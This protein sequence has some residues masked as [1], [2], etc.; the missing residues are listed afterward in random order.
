[1][2]WWPT[3]R[4]GATLDDQLTVVRG[5]EIAKTG[6]EYDLSSGPATFTVEDLADAI[7]SQDDP[8]IVSP[9]IAPGH[10]DPRF[11]GEPSLGKVINLRTED[12]G[13]TL[14]GDYVGV[15]KWFAGIMASAYPSRS[16]EG[17][18]NVETHT[19]H[20]WRLVIT[21]VKLLGVCWPGI[22][23]IDDLPIVF[24]D[25]GPEG[26]TVN[27]EPME[28]VMARAN[29]NNAQEVTASV[30]AEDVRRQYYD[31]LSGEELWWWIRAMYLDPNELI[32]DDD[33]GQLYRVPFTVSGDSATFGD[34]VP[35]K[36]V[37]ED[38]PQK[39][40]ARLYTEGVTSA[41]GDRVAASFNS[42]EE[43]RPSVSAT[44]EGVKMDPD[45]LKALGL[46]DDATPEQVQTALRD[47]GISVTAETPPAPDPNP[48]DDDTGDGDGND[49]QTGD[50]DQ[51]AEGEPS[52]AQVLELA[53]KHGMALVDKST[54]E[55]LKA[56]AKTAQTIAASQQRDRKENILASAVKDGKIPPSRKDHYAK[57]YDADPE[58]T[59]QL[60]NQLAAGAVP[61]TERGVAG[62]DEFSDQEAYPASWFPE[63]AARQAQQNQPGSG[64]I[65]R[66]KV[67]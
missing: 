15:P 32:V 59:E 14:I 66:E 39:V 5:V 31:S 64:Q 50:G 49:Q 35:V 12:E 65:L 43:S 2:T 7:A 6:I 27:G 30:N 42:R 18:R 19:G 54:L 62:G 44:R 10:T 52:T 67:S 55:E 9:R 37:Y 33:E 22:S 26:V 8:A 58:G 24:S 23:T 61:V 17:N 16:I 3:I 38:V 4:A 13:H 60:L 45:V 57:M 41:R 47:K 40:A 28:V 63:L 34:P 51:P 48:E 20:R 29:P 1:L 21:A 36:I 25:E 53:A 46:A 11:D 56:G